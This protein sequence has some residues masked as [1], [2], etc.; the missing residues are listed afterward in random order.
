MVTTIPEPEQLAKLPHDVRAMVMTLRPDQL[1]IL[2]R[3]ISG[4][5]NFDFMKL[6]LEIREMIY[7]YVVAPNSGAL[8]SRGVTG[9]YPK[10]SEAAMRI[11]YQTTPTFY[12]S[13]PMFTTS[14]V[15]CQELESFMFKTI[16]F[17]I[18]FHEQITKNSTGFD[19]RN[20]LALMKFNNIDIY[21][22]LKRG[23]VF[24]I[25]TFGGQRRVA[26]FLSHIL[27]VLAKRAGESVVYLNVHFHHN[28]GKINA[29]R[30]QRGLITVWDFLDPSHKFLGTSS[31]HFEKEIQAVWLRMK[32][33]NMVLRWHSELYIYAPNVKVKTNTTRSG[34]EVLGKMVGSKLVRFK[35]PTSRVQGEIALHKNG[36]ELVHSIIP[37]WDDSDLDTYS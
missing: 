17:R 21:V 1:S 35:I 30:A 7:A 6:P 12:Q 33:R 2:S 10:L 8:C 22:F 13:V 31:P 23:E 25:G 15:V 28:I 3:A 34:F 32:C 4:Y 27:A 5:V 20:D 29:F 19:E 11:L 26:A 16:R 37:G 24:D 14:T 36:R 9:K 18:Y